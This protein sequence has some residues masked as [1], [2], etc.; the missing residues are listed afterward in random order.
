M[1]SK[2]S[3]A[4]TTIKR[5]CGF[6]LIIAAVFTVLIALI[7]FIVE[8]EVIGNLLALEIN[9]VEAHYAN[10]GDVPEPLLPFVRYFTSK[11]AM[12]L[13]LPKSARELSSEGEIFVD[14]PSHFHVR[15][16]NLSQPNGSEQAKQLF[17][18][19]EVGPLLAVSQLGSNIM[20]LVVF[21]CVLGISLAIWQAYKLAKITTTPL[22]NLTS[23]VKAMND[24]QFGESQ[25]PHSHNE[26]EYVSN[27]IN[28][29]F[30]NLQ[31]ALARESSF[32]RD[33]SH[34]LRTPLTVFNNSIALI[35]QRGWAP[36]DHAKLT[37]SVKSMQFT[38]DTLLMLAREDS[39]ESKPVQLR[40][41]IEKTILNDYEQLKSA[42]VEIEIQVDDSRQVFANELI[43]ILILK[44]TLNNALE[45]VGACVYNIIWDNGTLVFKNTLS[46]Q[47]TDNDN[48]H[49]LASKPSFGLGNRLVHQL[50]GRM[51]W[52][53]EFTS[54][55]EHYQ[56]AL[57]PQPNKN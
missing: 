53:V 30:K 24:K 31:E 10:T 13:I 41:C 32:T 23:T 45:H 2:P 57:H 8:D 9:H 27:A 37:A 21:V 34:E 36:A 51:N 43:L 42:G 55:G 26:I 35:E 5:F 38:I 17:L 16:L 49:S 7:A 29:A 56:V 12:Q 3:V 4:K 52:T 28:F 19:A 47:N 54:S 15:T 40:Q 18:L 50:A 22:S 33:V 6:T 25:I 46:D 20:F 48:K 44:N 39:I 11:Q 14:G 1:R